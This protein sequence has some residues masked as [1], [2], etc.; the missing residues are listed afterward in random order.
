MMLR[1]ANIV[2]RIPELNRSSS[3]PI[4]LLPG[5]PKSQD[6]QAEDG[7]GTDPVLYYLKGNFTYKLVAE[8]IVFENQKIQPVL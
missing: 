8:I 1:V 4:W 2:N 7:A 6:P 3:K 5:Q